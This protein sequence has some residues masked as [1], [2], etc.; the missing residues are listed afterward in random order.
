AQVKSKILN[1]Y[2]I[3]KN[4]VCGINEYGKLIESDFFLRNKINT[5]SNNM[6]ERE[7]DLLLNL[8][9]AGYTEEFGRNDYGDY[10]KP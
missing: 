8:I 9:S 10:N 5:I 3:G 6:K 2:T 7:I 4:E 1:F